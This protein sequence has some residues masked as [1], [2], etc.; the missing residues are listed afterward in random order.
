MLLKLNASIEKFYAILGVLR[1]DGIAVICSHRLHTSHGNWN[2]HAATTEI[3]D[4]FVGAWRDKDSLQR[5][6]S[7]SGKC[8]VEFEVDPVRALTIAAE[9]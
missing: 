8:K 2:C 5:W 3:E 6:P 7:Y 9:L 4:I 1:G